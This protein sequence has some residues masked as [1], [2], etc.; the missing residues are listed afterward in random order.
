MRPM[1]FRVPA[2]RHP[3]EVLHKARLMAPRPHS[4]RRPSMPAAIR[5]CA[6]PCSSMWRTAQ[7]AACASRP[8]PAESTGERRRQ[9]HKHGAESAPRGR[10]ARG[11]SAFFEAFRMN[12]RARVDFANVRGVQFLEPLFEFSGA[13]AGCGET[14]YL[15]LLS[16]LFGDRL[17]VANATG[18]SS[19]YGAQSSGDAMDQEPGGPRSGMVELAVRGQRRVRAR[20]PLRRRQAPAN[21]RAT[22]S[23]SLHRRLARI[24]SHAI[25][26]RRRSRESEIRA[27]RH[28]DGR[29]EAEAARGS[30][31][32]RARASFSGRSS[33]AAQHLDRR[34]RRLGVRH[35]LWRARPCAGIGPQRQHS[36]ARH[37]GLFEHRRPGVQGDA[38]G[39]GRQVRG[40]G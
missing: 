4:N 38:A 11:I 17:L 3:R 16:Q 34:R 31:S 23:I 10:R 37:R 22:A 25:L 26:T 21:W 33:G 30:T 15:K 8:V 2:Q 12:D 7:G 6:S 36:G 27:Q 20:L 40:C 35:R 9:G 19:I 5:K 14:P 18:C 29:A 13:C 39:R 1:Q 24:S 28:R 32:R